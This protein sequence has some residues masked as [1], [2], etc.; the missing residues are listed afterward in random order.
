MSGDT[1]LLTCVVSNPGDTTLLWKKHS[2]NRGEN[3]LLTA[4][5]EVVASDP[6][7][8]VLHET[9]GNVY[10][11]KISNLTTHDAGQYLSQSRSQYDDDNDNDI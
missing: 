8:A 10:V 4:G 3:I 7:V 9:G 6:R 5:T 1:A 2:K 11:L